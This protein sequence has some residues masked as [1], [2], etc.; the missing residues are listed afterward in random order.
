MRNDIEKTFKINIFHLH[1]YNNCCKIS[2]SQKNDNGAI[3]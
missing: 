1:N 3:L 2:E